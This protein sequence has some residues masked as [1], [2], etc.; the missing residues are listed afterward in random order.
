MG[1]GMLLIGGNILTEI[2]ERKPTDATT[3]GFVVSE[4]ATVCAQNFI[5][6]LRVRGRKSAMEATGCTKKEGL[7]PKKSSVPRE[8]NI[9]GHLFLDLL[10]SLFSNRSCLQ[11]Q[12]IASVNSEFDIFAHRSIQIAYKPIAPV[13]GNDLEFFIPAN[14][15]TYI[16]IDIKLYVLGKCPRSR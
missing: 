4:H 8:N 13:E 7:K 10:Q 11:Q 5:S 16:D 1:S 14:N 2:A 9:K 3:A 6:K 15:V 12:E